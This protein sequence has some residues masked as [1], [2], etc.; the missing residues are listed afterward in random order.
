MF[1]F[2]LHRLGLT[3]SELKF[4]LAYVLELPEWNKLHDV[5]HGGL[6]RSRAQNSIVAVQELH[7]AEVRPSYPDDDDG[8]GQLRGVDDGAARLVHVCDHSV[9][10]DQQDKV[11]L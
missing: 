10:D 2:V 8:H 6:A 4:A 7:G 3:K 11:L 1:C 5:P 9:G